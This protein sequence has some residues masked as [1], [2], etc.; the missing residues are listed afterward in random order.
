M[1]NFLKTKG[2]VTVLTAILLFCYSL[3]YAQSLDVSGV[4]NADGATLL[5]A[6]VQVKNSG[7]GTVTDFDGKFALSV[8]TGDVLVVGFLGYVTQEYTVT[9]ADPIVIDLVSDIESLSELVVVGYGVQRKKEVTGAVA[10]VSSEKLAKM[11]TPNLATSL[12]GQV[13]GVNIQASSGRPGASSNV[14]IRGL[15]SLSAGALS[16]LYVVDGIPVGGDPNLAPEQI[17][18]IDFLKDG[19]SAAIYGVRASNGVIIITTKKGSEGSMKIDF[20]SYAG[21]QNITS[22]TPLMDATDQ[23]YFEELKATALGQSPTFVDKNPDA[24]QN[25]TDYVSYMEND[26]ALIQNYSLNLSGGSKNLTFNTNLSYFNQEGVII[27][28]GYERLSTRTTGQFTKGKFKASM[29]MAYTNTTQEREPYALYEHSMRQKPFNTEIS[30]IQP[31]KDG[32]KL[33]DANA[34]T[35]SYLTRNLENTDITKA[36]NFS[37]SLDAS[38][39]IMPGLKYTL[40]LG[41]GFNHSL[42]KRWQPRYVVYNYLDEYDGGASRPNAELR[43]N[44]AISLNQTWENIFSYNKEFGRHNLTLLGVL[45]YEQNVR[46]TFDITGMFSENHNNEIQMLGA[47]ESVSIPS[48]YKDKT[49][50]TGKLFR[51]QYNFADRYMMSASI[52]YDGSSKFAEVNRYETFPSASF[53][54]NVSEEQFFSSAKDVINNFKLRASVAQVGNNRIDS[55]SYI[56]TISGGSN[57][58]F[59]A[60]EA[61]MQGLIQRR[62]VDPSIKWETSN[63]VNLGLDLHFFESK[64]QFAADLYKTDK[65][66]MLLSQLLPP[67]SGTHAP[68]AANEYGVKVVNGGNMVNSGIE[69]ALSYSGATEYGLTYDVSSTFTMNRNEVTSLNGTQIGYWGGRPITSLG[70]VDN[71]TCLAV[72]HEAGAFFLVK[73][74]GVIKTE[75]ELAEYRKVDPNANMGDV[76]FKDQLT[77]DTDGDGVADAG[78]GQIDDND[79]VYCGSGQANFEMGMNF[80]L[81]YENW[82]FYIRG[83]WSQGAEIYNGSKAFAYQTGRHADQVHS[84]SPQNPTTGIPTYRGQSH[85]NFRTYSDMYLEDGSYFRISTIS[86]GYTFDQMKD[87]G[88]ERCRLYV[89]TINPFTFTKYEGY[90]P[91]VGGD[92]LFMRGVDQGNYPVARQ[93]LLGL[94]LSF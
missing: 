2:K 19:A 52:R 75:D 25:N 8:N 78:D 76:M 35:F 30:A 80:N 36:N 49:T 37:V 91:E 55:Y 3:G 81:G 18:S 15:G 77:V 56:P 29:V 12:Q 74:E 59:G 64:L 43:E 62:F 79:R 27:N 40:R 90:D 93:F 61:L 26:N 82:D 57:Y 86:L 63:S 22:S 50:L 89:S 84:W 5:G 41:Q 83:L 71:T 13:A 16:P 33:P 48:T 17:E 51:F 58:P 65:S 67:S 11:S 20:S 32:V 47:A 28:S 7:N 1:N 68:G 87:R 66:D 46:E 70:G 6:T 54:W 23:L 73:T 10:N 14:Q 92:G 9:T 38:Y 24:L 44:S 88:I 69:L 31:Y 34:E 94:Q 60:D 4:V 85:S 45:S 21:V 39:E 72:G 42:R 53:G